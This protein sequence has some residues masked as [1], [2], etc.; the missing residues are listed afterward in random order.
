MST[1]L[2]EFKTAIQLKKKILVIKDFKFSVPRETELPKEWQPY[3]DYFQNYYDFYFIYDA[4]HHEII[5]D[6]ILEEYDKP[7][8][9]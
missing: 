8:V 3:D 2:L 4:E 1:S 6:R 5:V 7:L 9:Q